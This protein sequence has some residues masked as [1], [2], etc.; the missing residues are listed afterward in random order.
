MLWAVEASQGRG[1]ISPVV[2]ADIKSLTVSYSAYYSF[3]KSL[4]TRQ[5]VIPEVAKAN[6]IVRDVDKLYCNP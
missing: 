6:I 5:E 2:V 1:V 3:S 4:I